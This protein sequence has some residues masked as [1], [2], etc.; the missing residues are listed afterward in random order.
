MSDDGATDAIAGGHTETSIPCASF[1]HCAS[2]EFVRLWEALCSGRP[3]E[4]LLREIFAANP[5]KVVVGGLGFAPHH[6]ADASPAGT[7]QGEAS[8]AV[9]WML[10]EVF[11][12]D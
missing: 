4:R 8:E 5:R 2:S 9:G 6:S 12:I 11:P 3:F 10:E 7:V 1:P